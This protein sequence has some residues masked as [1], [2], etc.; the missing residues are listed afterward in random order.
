MSEQNK[1]HIS[2]SRDSHRDHDCLDSE[3]NRCRRP[4]MGNLHLHG[5]LKLI[6]GPQRPIV[7]LVARLRL[8]QEPAS[9]EN[10]VVSLKPEMSVNLPLQLRARPVPRQIAPGYCLRTGSEIP[11]P[12]RLRRGHFPATEKSSRPMRSRCAETLFRHADE[13]R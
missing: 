9:V 3:Q 12:S 11:G 8:L 4:E 5:V 13:H 7:Q 6:T 10:S 2:R 1:L